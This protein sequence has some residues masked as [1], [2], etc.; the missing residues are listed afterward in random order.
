MKKSAA[1]VLLSV[2]VSVLVLSVGLCTGAEEGGIPFRM[3]GHL[4]TVDV[5]INDLQ[6][7]YNFVV[8][9]GGLTFVDKKLADE[10]QLK[11][12]G[13]QAKIN[14]LH[15]RGLAIENV[16]CF[17]TFDF[18]HFSSLSV[19]IHGIIGSNLLERFATTFDFQNG[20]ITLSSEDL[21]LEKPERGLW[22]K[23]K[24]HRVNNAPLVDLKINGS[25]QEA[26]IDTG[27]PHTLV[28][29]IETFEKYGPADYTDHIKSKGLMEK[30]PGNKVNFNYMVRMKTLEL[31]GAEFD[32]TLCLFGD[33]PSLLSMPLIGTDFLSQFK[34][35]INFPKDEMVMIPNQDFH[36]RDNLYSVGLNVSLSES[37]E[38]FVEG[39]WENSPADKAG[40]KVDD[41]ILSFNSRKVM[42]DN[43]LELQSLLRDDQTGSIELEIISQ[44]EKRRVHLKKEFL[45]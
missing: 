18:S 6:R 33:L 10:L 30:W 4:M 17:T 15:L 35:I 2:M 19:P 7:D 29:P 21:N 11:Q 23:F 8:D 3:L 20:T 42:S 38:V 13:P 39:I 34:I 31:G 24:N 44:G 43:L 25:V 36:L 26:M 28:L 5:K 41:I 16:F 27:Q 22:L 12:V 40:V 1:S 14:M 37:N 9:T 45:F 32:N